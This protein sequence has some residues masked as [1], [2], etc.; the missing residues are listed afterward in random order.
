MPGTE[1]IFFGSRIWEL[2][3]KHLKMFLDRDANIV[4]FAEADISNISTTVTKKDPYEN[5][6]S[7]AAR[8]KIPIY[9]ANNMN[10]QKFLD[11]LRSFKADIFIVCGFQFYLTEEILSIPPM[12]VLNFHS[13]LLPRHAG[14]HPG[15]FTIYYGDKESGM[16]IHYMDMGLD[17]G[18]IVYRSKVPVYMGDDIASLYERI[19][20][21]SE[22]LIDRLLR[23]LDK[24]S[25]SR[26]P[27][28]M[29]KYFYNYE[30]SDKDFELDFRIEAKILFGR[31]VMMPGK[32]Y[33]MYNNEKYYIKECSIIKEPSKGRFYILRKPFLYKD[34]LIFIT[35]KNYLQIDSIL[36]EGKEINPLS[37]LN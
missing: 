1:I 20:D 19:W 18:D 5:I 16:T 30:I 25:L 7:V 17:T 22:D 9:C 28:D 26:I 2:T 29:S 4:A 23:D 24:K 3:S 31:V 33:F 36:K 11:Y 13:S 6:S 35:P 14:M 21:S 37:V 12:G 32:F 27:Q 8:L 15:F 34:K 10:D